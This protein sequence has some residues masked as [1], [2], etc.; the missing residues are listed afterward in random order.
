MVNDSTGISS[1]SP[2]FPLSGGSEFLLHKR[3]DSITDVALEDERCLLANFGTL[4]DNKSKDAGTGNKSVDVKILV[5][6]C[7]V[8]IFLV[9]VPCAVHMFI[10]YR[11]RTKGDDEDGSGGDGKR[12]RGRKGGN[13]AVVP[14]WP[15]D[16]S[17]VGS[18]P[19]IAKKVE[20]YEYDAEDEQQPARTLPSILLRNGSNASG[21]SVASLPSGPKN[22]NVP[23]PPINRSASQQ[24]KAPTS[25]SAARLDGK[26][27][28]HNNDHD[29]DGHSSD[30]DEMRDIPLSPPLSI[31]PRNLDLHPHTPPS[32][33]VHKQ[34]TLNLNDDP[35]YL[36][37]GKALILPAEPPAPPPPATKGGY[38]IANRDT[39]YD[40]ILG[41]YEVELGYAPAKQ[42]EDV[43]ADRDAESVPNSPSP[44]ETHAPGEKDGKGLELWKALHGDSAPPP[45]LKAHANGHHHHDHDDG[46]DLELP[47]PSSPRSAVATPTSG[48]RAVYHFDGGHV[49]EVI[50]FPPAYPYARKHGQKTPRTP[51]TGG[52]GAGGFPS[53]GSVYD[54]E[55]WEDE[56]F[57]GRAWGDEKD[58]TSHSFGLGALATLGGREKELRDGM[59]LNVTSPVPAGVKYDYDDVPSPSYVEREDLFHVPPSPMPSA[60]TPGGGRVSPKSPSFGG[61]LQAPLSAGVRTHSPLAQSTVPTREDEKDNVPPAGPG[62]LRIP[63]SVTR[64]QLSDG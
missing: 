49:E 34:K 27:E 32:E 19:S 21:K 15:S 18:V 10:R 63:A 61:Q 9:M 23:A 38:Q 55:E 51:Q 16:T 22:G 41:A 62:P 37:P 2:K 20:P 57:D 36:P 30:G 17:S 29:H 59:G 40:S 8:A 54:D 50:E 33:P 35:L 45:K 42:K 25:A 28:G 24:S 6:L 48:R 4:V 13:N 3:H 11:T 60:L 39:M 14:R 31:A 26:E 44:T 5:P 64:Y 46:Q 7:I 47:R 52:T 12:R 58:M 53:P 56:K 1:T 43:K